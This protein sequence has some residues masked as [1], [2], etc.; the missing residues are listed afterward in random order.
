MAID[1]TSDFVSFYRD[2]F[3]HEGA[4]GPRPIIPPFLEGW[5]RL[6]FP[7][8]EGNPAERNIL[9]SRS[10]KQGK[11]ALAGGVA[12]YMASRQRHAEV[13]I[14][15]A[16]RDQAKD[17]VLKAIK[18][19][20][21]HCQVWRSA[22]VY[23]DVIEL[24]NKSV[25]QAIPFDWRGAAGGNYAAVIFDELHVFTWEDHRRLFDELVIPPTQPH[26]VRWISSYAGYEGESELLWDIWHK[27][28]VGERIPG[29]LPI[30]HNPRAA[31]M[32]LID[33][34]EASWRMPWTTPEFMATIRESERPSVYRR[35]WLNEWVS[36]ESQFLP[37]GAW[38]A[39]Y[40][41]QVKA[42]AL[43]DR[44]RVVLAADASTS[45]DLTALV[46]CAYDHEGDHV[47][48]VLVKTWKPKVLEHAGALLRGGKP[49]VDLSGIEA[50]ILRIHK[51][52]ILAACY[53]DPYQLHSISMNLAK[54]GVRMV[55]LPQTS[56]RTEADQ[57]LYDAVLGKR[58]RHFDHHELNEHIRNAVA[59]ESVRGW[60][61]AKE[62]T[63]R[64]IDAAVALSMA[65]FAALQELKSIPAASLIADPFQDWGI[66]DHEGLV[67]H[68]ALGYTT[69]KEIRR[70][71]AFEASGE[72]EMWRRH[73]E[74]IRQQA[75][76]RT[77]EPTRQESYLEFLES[78]GVLHGLRLQAQEE[79]RKHDTQQTFWINV[80][81]RRRGSR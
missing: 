78:I 72:N 57:A 80:S 30:Y 64:K 19:A 63:S 10:K 62:R 60:R 23:R 49:T 3:P 51:M 36:S 56:R 6:C 55:E 22:K 14:S 48:V 34:G 54:E 76:Q 35:I 77:R 32:A 15:A 46:G 9:D 24:D 81:R 1:Y 79:Q 11:S 74:I 38:E 17:R 20:V 26:G 69:P 45:R 43:D 50:E 52:G 25:I 67:Y 68:P 37:G 12:L 2:L 61:L 75:S 47:D 73:D 65:H 5:M 7:L 27:A 70:W 31:L 28:L 41:D 40:S 42:L 33:Q 13:I 8:P 21:E 59:I 44:R 18:Y 39:C 71:E 4:Y 16:D 53:Y 66:D 58:L 29:D